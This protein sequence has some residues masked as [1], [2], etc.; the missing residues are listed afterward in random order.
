M[1]V[2]AAQHQAIFRAANTAHTC[3][4]IQYPAIRFTRNPSNTPTQNL[5]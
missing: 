1:S 5:A 2:N 4:I 3:I